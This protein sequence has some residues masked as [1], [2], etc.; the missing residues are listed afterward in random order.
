MPRPCSHFGSTPR[1]EPFRQRALGQ[2]DLHD[3]YSR[4]VADI[5]QRDEDEIY[6]RGWSDRFEV[7][8][9]DRDLYDLYARKAENLYKRELS[10]LNYIFGRDPAGNRPSSPKPK[11]PSPKPPSR[12]GTPN[13]EDSGSDLSSTK[14]TT[15]LQMGKIKTRTDKKVRLFG[16]N[17]CTGIFL[18]GQGFIT[19]A[20][21]NPD[22]V[23]QTAISAA[24][25]AKAKG[26]V[27]SIVV[28]ASNQG[29]SAKATDALRAIFPSVQVD[30]KFYKEDKGDKA[31]YYV[32]DAT[33]GNPTQT[34][35]TYTPP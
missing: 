29:D 18:F 14:S 27:T 15:F 31:G 35:A 13:A 4:D 22:E 3:I 2:R 20:H 30:K 33:Q 10:R 11:S 24:D 9:R 8:E 32:F 1:G 34:T 23:A 5:Y 21:A 26:T 25:Q 12:P 16:L 17:G 7:Y 19:G 28:Y 6:A